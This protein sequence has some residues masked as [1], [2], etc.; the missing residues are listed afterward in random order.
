M[1]VLT[2]VF[3]L[4]EVGGGLFT[5]SLALLAD[6][7]HML[8]DVAALA[9]AFAAVRLAKR[10]AD[11][12]RSYGWH[13]AQTLAAFVNGLALI[14]I[15]LWIAAEAVLRLLHPNGIAG[16]PMLAIAG[17]G[18]V[19]NLIGM[20]LL[21][22]HGHDLNMRAAWL[23]IAADLFGSIATMA[24]AGAILAFGWLWV[25]PAAS[26]LLSLL[27]LFGAVP[28]VRTTGHILLEGAP[29]GLDEAHLRPALLDAVP[30]LSDI[31]HV[32][33]WSLTPGR[34]LVTLHAVVAPGSDNQSVLVALQQTLAERFEVGHATIQIEESC[35]DSS[36]DCHHP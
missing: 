36:P 29:Q 13:R 33:A 9:L 32:H 14:A 25:D 23:H 10:P 8:T 16:G 18:F 34:W 17:G 30:G 15:S 7:G 19:V 35:L 22:G 6:A 4:V 26:A 24:A 27:I 28:L 11:A 21:H 31:H 3:M 1:L 20:S 2:F 5:G 12:L